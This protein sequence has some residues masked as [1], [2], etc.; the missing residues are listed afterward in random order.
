MVRS[1]YE[2]GRFHIGQAGAFRVLGPGE[3]NTDSY[4]PSP[5]ELLA[6]GKALFD[7]GKQEAA[8]L[9]LEPL[10]A[11]YTL[12][13]DVAKD[14]ARMLLMISHRT[15]RRA[16]DRPVLRGRPRRNRPS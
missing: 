15:L 2:P 13:D 9:A 14:V 8:A 6:R 5:D 11:G 12:R 16:E 10:F 4:K 1:A 3:K 7:A